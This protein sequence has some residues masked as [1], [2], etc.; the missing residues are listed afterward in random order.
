MATH[1]MSGPGVTPAEKTRGTLMILAAA[2]GWASSGTAAKHL[3]LLGVT[4][5]GLVQMRATLA[6]VLIGLW[7]AMTRPALFRV[8]TRDLPRILA[9]GFFG[10]AMVQFTYLFAISRVHVAVA[11][12][13]QYMAPVFIFFWSLAFGAKKPKLLSAAAITV[14]VAGCYFVSGAY[15]FDFTELDL[16]GLGSGLASAV[17]FAVYTLLGEGLV[18]RYDP[19]AVT[20]HAFL[21][22]AVTWNV[23][24]APFA[25][26]GKCADPAFLFWGLYV[27]VIGTVVPFLLYVAGMRSVSS[28]NASITA[29]T[30]PIFA[31]LI[32]WVFIGEALTPVQIAGAALVLLSV[33]VLTARG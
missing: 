14:T 19:K 12:L 2:L 9:L 10:M 25:F 1:D 13:M 20:F 27:A 6:A 15:D 16:L 31:G 30:E 29:T 26:V 11:I 7:I 17:S 21:V 22:A 8:K 18:G 4:P 32:S 23:M 28:V 3:F 5:A 24:D 33:A